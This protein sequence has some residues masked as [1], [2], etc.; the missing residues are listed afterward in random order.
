MILPSR[1]LMSNM[2]IIL[3]LPW[4][5]KVNDQTPWGEYHSLLIECIPSS[6]IKRQQ[7]LIAFPWKNYFSHRL[8]Q[9]YSKK[10]NLITNKNKHPPYGGHTRDDSRCLSLSY[11]GPMME[12]C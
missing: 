12:D 7:L 9:S 3:D 1:H 11:Y 2:I 4:S 5:S 8:P 10:S 6:R